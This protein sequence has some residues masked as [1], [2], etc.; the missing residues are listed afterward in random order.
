MPNAIN[1]A[2]LLSKNYNIKCETKSLARHLHIWAGTEKMCRECHD[3]IDEI[4]PNHFQRQNKKIKHKILT[5]AK[6]D[7]M[8]SKYNRKYSHFLN[9]QNFFLEY[10]NPEKMLRRLNWERK[11][12]SI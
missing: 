10:D 5:Q 3:K 11:K 8:K 12:K 2:R 7:K 9:T 1:I 4:T 6:K